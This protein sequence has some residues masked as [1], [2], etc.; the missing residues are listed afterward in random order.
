MGNGLLSSEEG[1]SSANFHTTPTGGR[2][3]LNRFNVQPP[4][5][6]GGS[7]IRTHDTQPRVLGYRGPTF[8]PFTREKQRITEMKMNVIEKKEL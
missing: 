6:Y 3:G 1:D 2:L 4:S 5:L 7:G 8:I